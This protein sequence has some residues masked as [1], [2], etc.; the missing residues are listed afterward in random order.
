M[1]TPGRLFATAILLTAA[2]IPGFA[3]QPSPT[4]S[5]WYAGASPVLEQRVF[6]VG[7]E[8]H[9]SY[10]LGGTAYGGYL[11]TPSVGLQV[12]ILHGRGGT[13]DD[14]HADDGTAKYVPD[15][16]KESVWGVPVGVRVQFSRP[17]R[18]LQLDGLLGASAY[19]VRQTHTYNRLRGQTSAD[20]WDPVVSRQR[21]LNGYINAG[22]GLRY[23]CSSHWQAV[24]D[25]AVNLNTKRTGYY[26]VGPGASTSLGVRYHF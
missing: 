14:N 9:G 5:R 7:A 11:L 12:G 24:A 16:Y 21:A 20:G 25:A 23:V 6:V 22:L 26:G 18:R 10:L 2:P 8:S 15:S 3:Q 1:F 17:E 4:P 13:M 19:A